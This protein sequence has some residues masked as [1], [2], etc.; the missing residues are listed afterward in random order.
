MKLKFEKTEVR[1]IMEFGYQMIVLNRTVVWA[2][3]Y[4][5]L[6]TIVE[7]IKDYDYEMPKLTTEE[8]KIVAKSMSAEKK[9]FLASLLKE[10]MV[11]SRGDIIYEEP[12]FL[13]YCRE[14]IGLPDVD[15]EEANALLE[16]YIGHIEL[17]RF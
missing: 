5:L 14:V 4:N 11:F 2:A 8:I 6:H 3:K 13:F 12:E 15:Y 1:T 9:R 7:S 17:P 16:E 10:I